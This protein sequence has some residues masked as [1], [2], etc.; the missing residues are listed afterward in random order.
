M[1]KYTRKLF[2]NWF[3]NLELT[4]KEDDGRINSA[5]LKEFRLALRD[6][7][8]GHSYDEECPWSFDSTRRYELKTGETITLHNPLQSAFPA[9]VD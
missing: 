2:L 4:A 1:L 6:E 7:S 9:Y 3:Y 8:K 5:K